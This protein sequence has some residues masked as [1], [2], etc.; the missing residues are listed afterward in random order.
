MEAD[1]ETQEQQQDQEQLQDKPKAVKATSSYRS[2]LKE[3]FN[4]DILTK[5]FIVQNAWMIVIVVVGLLF[6]I[7]NH[8]AVI[9]DLNEIDSLK[10]QLTDVKYDALTQSSILMRE[11]R[12]S[13]IHE[14]IEEKGLDLEDSKKPPYVI[15]LEK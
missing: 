11:S 4:G 13:R 6:Y 7:G 3:V 10:E 1:N 14:L 2:F 8:Y 9:M 12:Q 15:K 5:G